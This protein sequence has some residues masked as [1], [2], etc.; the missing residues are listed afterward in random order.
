MQACR[1]WLMI[2]S[3]CFSSQRMVIED[4]N[5]SQKRIILYNQNC[6]IFFIFNTLIDSL[7]LNMLT[8]IVFVANKFS[9][10]SCL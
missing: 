10:S 2:F 1:V 5:N 8:S 9:P 4:T 7:K 6:R 3:S